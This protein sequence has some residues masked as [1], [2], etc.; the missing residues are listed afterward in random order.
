MN[1]IKESVHKLIG[2]TI[3]RMGLSKAFNITHNSIICLNGSE[4]IFMGLLRNV[5]QIKSTEGIDYCWVAEAHNVPDESWEILIPTVRKED[6]EIIIDFNPRYEDDPTYQ[7]WVVNPPEGTISILV[8]HCDNPYF[9]EVLRLE[10]E[11]DKKKDPILYQQKWM[12]KPIGMGGR[13]WPMFDTSLHI[14]TIPID[15]IAKK[16]HCVMA[17]DPH[18]HFYPACVWVALMPTNERMNYPEDF[19]MHVYEEYPGIDDLQAPYH[20]QRKKITFTGSLSDISR[21][22]FARDGYGV[23][24][25]KRS[26]DTRF[27]KGSGGWNWSTSTQGIVQEFAKKEN[28]GILFNLPLEKIIDS[29]RQVIQKYM[30]YNKLAPIN[31]FNKPRFSVDPKCQNVIMSLKNHRL[32]DDPYNRGDLKEKESEKYKDFSD[33]LRI[34]SATIDG[35]KSPIDKV[36]KPTYYGGG[37]SF[38]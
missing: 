8:N 13:V 31:D 28:G 10:M 21:E 30:D 25:Q 18:S 33:A 26:I 29:Q 7:R 38:G 32:E 17:M 5:D 20:E 15:V 2:D 14:Q 23:K 9:P 11:Y 24:I 12:G 22:I 35:Y 6:S 34:A 36:K 37:S 1:S 3:D 19:L 16:G 27:A 4:F